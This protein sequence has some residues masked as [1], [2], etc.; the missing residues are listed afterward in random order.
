MSDKAYLNGLKIIRLLKNAGFDARFVG[1]CVRDRLAGITP[2]DYD[3]ATTAKPEEVE[4]IMNKKKL[5]T[6]PIGLKHGTIAVRIDSTIFEVTTLR[7]DVETDGRHAKVVFTDSFKEDASRRDFTINAMSEDESGKIYDYF[8]GIE[9]LKNKIIRFVGN[10]DERIKE[11]FLRIL[12][13]F[14]FAARFC[15]QMDSDTLLAIEQLAPNL[16]NLSNERK[17]QE[18][19]GFFVTQHISKYLQ[20]MQNTKVLSTIFPDLKI[21]LPKQ[22]FACFDDLVEFS[23]LDF[24]RLARWSLLFGQ[25]SK[26]FLQSS[27]LLNFKLSKQ[28]I[29][30]ILATIVLPK[31]FISKENEIITNAQAFTLLNTLEKKTF[32]SFFVKFY[33]PFWTIFD[34]YFPSDWLPILSKIANIEEKY[35]HLR[36]ASLPITGFD[37]CQILQLNEGPQVGKILVDLQEAFWNGKWY[38]KQEGIEYLKISKNQRKF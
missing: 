20:E 27:N 29:R 23:D 2:K 36:K 18:F 12:R 25:I 31:N 1:G 34:R 33:L 32:P 28:E 37:V 3:I 7:Q 9:D 5:Q 13:Y 8:S 22:A 19:D 26:D 11:D 16:K 4:N 17:K 14:R 38:S 10:P 24:R 6:I 21:P 15:L 30:H 35:G